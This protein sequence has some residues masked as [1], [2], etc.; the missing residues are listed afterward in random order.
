MMCRG[1][2]PFKDGQGAMPRRRPPMS[3]RERQRVWQGRY[4]A[5]VRNARVVPDM[6]DIAAEEVSFSVE[7]R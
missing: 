5:R 1:S 7:T 6:P 3:R 4:R 2:P